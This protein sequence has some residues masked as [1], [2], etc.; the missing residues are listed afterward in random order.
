MPLKFSSA[1]HPPPARYVVRTGKIS[2][3]DHP[4]FV[5]AVKA[6][7]RKTLII[8]GIFSKMAQEIVLQ[9]W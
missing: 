8:A 4:D 7:G 5:T 9:A 3:R 2:A 1:P 6:I